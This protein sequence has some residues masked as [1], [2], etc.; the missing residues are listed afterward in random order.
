MIS[1]RPPAVAGFFYPSDARDLQAEI[2]RLMAVA[3]APRRPPPKALIAPHAGY[4]YSGAIAASG[5]AQ[6]DGLRGRVSRVAL[7]GPAHRVAVG[8]LAVPTVAAFATPLGTVDIDRDAIEALRDHPA[9]VVSDAAHATEHSLEVHLPFLQHMLGSFSLIPLAVGQASPQDVAA[10]LG[11]L[12]GG[13]ETLVVVSSDLSHYLGYTQAC[14]RDEFTAQSI[15][16]FK[17][18]IAHHQAC[19]ATPINGLLLE[20]RER[21]LSCELVDLRNS[22]DTAGDKSRVVGYAA[23]VFHEPRQH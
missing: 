7:L 12:W 8:G 2:S 1:I 11:R 4:I 21:G 14:A 16:R 23:F 3:P 15:L 10:V 13:P 20:A 6:L 5:Y 18:D 17:P 22:G 9:V 19:G